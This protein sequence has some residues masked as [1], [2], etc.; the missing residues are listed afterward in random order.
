MSKATIVRCD[1]CKQEIDAEAC[2][3]YLQS[4]IAVLLYL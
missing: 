1:Y 2:V 3:V 4:S